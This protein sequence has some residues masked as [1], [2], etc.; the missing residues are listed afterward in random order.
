MISYIVISQ[1]P[2]YNSQFWS[3][4]MIW[5]PLLVASILY[6]YM[7][8][9]WALVSFVPDP[10][11]SGTP[12]LELMFESRCTPEPSVAQQLHGPTLRR[13]LGAFGVK[14]RVA[15]N[16]HPT[17]RVG[18][19]EWTK[20]SWMIH[21]YLLRGQYDHQWQ[22]S[23]KVL[24]GELWVTTNSTCLTNSITPI[25]PMCALVGVNKPKPVCRSK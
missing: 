24:G 8:Y 1:T 6:P 13:L 22:W 14:K 18:M 15:L 12:R 23:F 3:K 7:S 4:V 17:V 21:V 16:G 10:I 9:V 19:S 20:N 2:K 5:A 11:L 25:C